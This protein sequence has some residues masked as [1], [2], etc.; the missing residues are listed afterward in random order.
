MRLLDTTTFELRNG[1]QNSF[2]QEGYAI[3]SHRWIDTCCINKNSAT[4]EAESINSMFKWYREARL[5]ITY[6]ADVTR[7]VE[8]PIT[9][10][11]VFNRASSEERSEWF[12]RGWT[13]QELLALQEMQ[14][15]DMDWTYMGTKREMAVT[16]ARVTRIDA[17]YL[18]GAENF[19]DACIA[20]KMSWM[21]LRKTTREEDMAYSMLGIFGITMTPQ[22]GEGQGAFMRLQETLMATYLFDESL[23]AWQMPDLSSDS[24]HGVRKDKWAPSE[25]GLLAASPEWFKDSGDIEMAPH[26][27]VTRSFAMTPQGLKAPI[28]RTLY[29]GEIMALEGVFGILWI[30]FVGTIFGGI[31]FLYLKHKLN[32]KAK[33][34]FAFALNCYRR[35]SDGKLANVEIYL[36][37]T[38]VDKVRY[39]YRKNPPSLVAK[40]IRCNELGIRFKSATDLGEG[41]VLQPRPGF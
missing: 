20:V 9:S 8:L 38:S 21:A 16:L 30:S 32:K 15:Y 26:E 1:D 22:Y 29:T 36:R 24:Q 37:P 14:F 11:R 7:D 3:L 2:C 18:S 41:V 6:L 25:W 39:R 28:R 33:E 19:R 12:F 34:D 17:R 5:C 40:R 35:D 13:L 31:G 27:S 23:F 10:P 4:E